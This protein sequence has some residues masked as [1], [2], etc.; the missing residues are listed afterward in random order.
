MQKTTKWVA[1]A[2]ASSVLLTGCG[3]FGEQKKEQIDPPKNVTYTKEEQAKQSGEKKVEAAKR[4]LYLVDKNGFVV[5]QALALPD[6]KDNAVIKQ[7]LEYLVKDGPVTNL[8]PNGF[9]A[10][11]P[12]NTT[13]NGVDI[14]DGT[15]IADFSAEFKKYK[16]EEERRIV[17]AI[18]WTLTQFKDVQRVKI[19]IDGQDLAMMPV[20]KT[21][22]GEGL[23]RA[24]GINF[25]DRQVLDVMNTKPVT[26]YFVAQ[27][28][29]QTYYVP[30]TR[31]IA[32]NKET[33]TK[34]GEVIAV[35]NELV[36]G[37]SYKSQLSSDFNAGVKVLTPPK[38]EGGKVTLNFNQ[39]IYGDTKKSMISNHVL[40]ALV[41]SLTE[42]KGVEGV[43]IQVDG[44][45]SIV[46]ENGEKLTAPV[47]RPQNVNTGSF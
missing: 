4:E 25:D 39:N 1:C 23:S 38:L 12:A 11:L 44:K 45:A 26:L 2:V 40:Q 21:P 16:K 20:D 22:I 29:K 28:N 13:V 9:Q 14:K 7:S 17:E 37:P 10:V 24:D 36:K 18:T 27:N 31:R 32:N 15:A 41:L 34:E 47:T 35:V 46:K 33:A 30:V 3:M 6:A 43:A 8:L 19:R 5:P 42:Q